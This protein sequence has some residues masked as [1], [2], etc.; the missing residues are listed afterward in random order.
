MIK[1][2]H[3]FRNL[4]NAN[5]EGEFG[6]LSQ[7]IKFCFSC[8]LFNHKPLITI[9]HVVFTLKDTLPR[10]INLRMNKVSPLPSGNLRDSCGDEHVNR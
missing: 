9:N 10:D 4:A 2:L 8:I 7:S 5:W 1:E 3:I 6:I